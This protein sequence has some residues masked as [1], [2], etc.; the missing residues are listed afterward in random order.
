MRVAFDARALTWTGIGRY[1]RSILAA[2]LA[3][4]DDT[5]YIILT[6]QRSRAAA[7]DIV[8]DNSRATLAFVDD[9]HYSWREH[10]VLRWQLRSVQA[11]LWHFTHFNVPFGFSQPYCVTI[12]DV[13]RFHFPGQIRRGLAQ[14]VAY[15]QIFAGAVRNAA[16]VVAV[17]EATAHDLLALPL[18]VPSKMTVIHEGVDPAFSHQVSES[19]RLKVRMLLDTREQYL[20]VVGVWM[21]HKNIP[22]ILAAFEQVRETYPRLKLVITGRPRPGY[23]NVVQRARRLGILEH[24]IF[25]G[26]VSESLLPALYAEA[27]ALVFPSLYEGFGLPA[28]EAAACGT[29]AVVSNVS[30]FPEVMRGAAQYVN[31]ESEGSIA[32]GI[33][34]TLQSAPRLNRAHLAAHAQQYTWTQAALQQHQ[35]Y[36]QL[37]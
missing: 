1:A 25:P 16:G 23:V 28:L 17:S 15:E 3:R 20:L 19:D 2:L 10:T 8:G 26:H 7:E 14:Q 32:A 6:G 34:R 24:I 27:A 5:N 13:T 31:P 9:A 36:Q 35:L 12:H 11:D 18:T 33:V 21:A 4:D 30:S 22:R 37:L 29:P